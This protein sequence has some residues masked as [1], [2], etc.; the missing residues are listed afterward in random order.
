MPLAPGLSANA[1]DALVFDNPT[2]RIV[3]A[4]GPR[5]IVSGGIATI[6]DLRAVAAA[7]GVTLG[8]VIH[9][10]DTQSGLLP[11]AL[12]SLY[13]REALG[14]D[15]AALLAQSFPPDVMLGHLLDA[16]LGG[17]QPVLHAYDEIECAIYNGP[18]YAALRGLIR[19]MDDPSGT[20]ALQQMLGGLVPPAALVAA[21]SAI[22][23]GIG[24][25]VTYEG[26]SKDEF[27]SYAIMALQPFMP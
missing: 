9:V 27:R 18:E 2:G 21:F 20:W 15:Q 12:H 4:K 10:F 5:V 26:S 23:R 19:S 13:Q 6:D 24:R 17:Q 11:A 14:G 8:K 22:I 3:Q 16:I 25:R 7:A 1:D